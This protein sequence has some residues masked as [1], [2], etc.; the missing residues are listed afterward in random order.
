MTNGVQLPPGAIPMGRG[1]SN[2]AG[3]QPA[4][5]A[6]QSGQPLL[7]PQ[8]QNPAPKKR[9]KPREAMGV[10]L[11]PWMIFTFVA[12]LFTLGEDLELL[13]WGCAG[14]C[15]LMGLLFIVVGAMGSNPIPM[16]LGFLCLTATCMSVPVGLVAKNEFM[17]PYWHISEGATYRNV[18]PRSVGAGMRDG[19]V[20]EFVEGTFVDTERSAGYMKAGEVYCA[21]PI[22]GPT[23]S[24]SQTIWA[25]GMNCCSQ[26]G[27]FTCGD[28]DDEKARGAVSLRETH[29]KEYGKAV[30]MAEATYEMKPHKTEPLLVS[31][32]SDASGYAD[33]MWWSGAAVVATA[34]LAH[35][36]SS[37]LAAIFLSRN[38]PQRRKD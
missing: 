29:F 12:C 37:L 31:W 1:N 28:V 33:K 17:E 11:L 26:K 4:P 7:G 24:V 35:L 30:K 18:D 36:V 34:S 23:K 22:S 5:Q 13:G 19:T 27:H 3:S 25:V 15:V 38:L 8:G 21:A 10:A 2:N 9:L 32:I 14:V 6:A 20:F 16:A